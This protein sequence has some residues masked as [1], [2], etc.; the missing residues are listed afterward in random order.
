MSKIV[1]F[2]NHAS[3]YISGVEVFQD[4]SDLSRRKLF[5]I[6]SMI[7][8][9]E[10]P[11][12]PNPFRQYF[13]PI[14]DAPEAPIEKWFE[15]TYFVI[16]SS[17]LQGNSVLV[18]CR[19]GI[20]RSVTAVI[21]FFLRSFR[22]NLQGYLVCPYVARRPHQRWTDALLEFIQ[23]KRPQAYPN[24]GFLRRLYA[25]EKECVTANDAIC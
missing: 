21:A 20:S 6:V 2:S 18:H 23:R 5:T 12:L 10:V 8:A 24:V 15:D 11:S 4:I 1:T 19:A 16:A 13:F 14:D 17:L 3:L 22:G 25:Y 9:D 7:H